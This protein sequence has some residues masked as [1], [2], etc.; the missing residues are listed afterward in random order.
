MNI[1]SVLKHL[2]DLCNYLSNLNMSFSVIGLSESWI[3]ETNYNLHSM[4]G[5]NQVEK[6]RENRVGGVRVLTLH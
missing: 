2:D 1:H 5:Y 3:N 4:V 6:F